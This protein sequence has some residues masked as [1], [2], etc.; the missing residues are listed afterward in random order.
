MNPDYE[1][2]LESSI[3]RALKS[4]PDLAAPRTLLPRIRAAL[5]QPASRPWYRQAWLAWPAPAR[6]VSLALLGCLFVAI[7]WGSAQVPTSPEV[8]AV[9]GE[10]NR[11][12]S[13]GDAI[14]RTAQDLCGTVFLLLSHLNPR[15]LTAFGLVLILA[16]G[17]CM[18]LGTVCV[19]LVFARP[20]PHE[21]ERKA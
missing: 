21:F 13:I 11:W 9:M 5:E 20:G 8:N 10:M 6:A 16:N 17:V 18:G 7:C 19:R 15:F 4:L 3:D 2:A 1:K 14:G 12:Q